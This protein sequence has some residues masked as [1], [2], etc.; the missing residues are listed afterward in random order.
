MNQDDLEYVKNARKSAKTGAII[1]GL[2][3]IL[4]G[5]ILTKYGVWFLAIPFFSLG[6]W[7]LS[8]GIR[9]KI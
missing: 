3:F 9:Y 1:M 6:A 7:R 4:I 2:T 5:I 8:V